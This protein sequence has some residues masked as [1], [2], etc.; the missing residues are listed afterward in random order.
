MMKER[1]ITAAVAIYVLMAIYT[2]GHAASRME[3]ICPRAVNYG[4]FRVTTICVESKF[5]EF[6]AVFWPFYWSAYFQGAK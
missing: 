4:E 1:L 3:L 6:S 5:P 2:Y